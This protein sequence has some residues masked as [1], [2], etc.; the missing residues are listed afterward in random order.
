MLLHNNGPFL[1]LDPMDDNPLG[2]TEDK[3]ETGN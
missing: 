3:I 2:P 1:I